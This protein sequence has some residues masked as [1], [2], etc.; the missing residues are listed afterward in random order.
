MKYCNC[1]DWVQPHFFLLLFPALT[2]G[3]LCLSPCVIH[4]FF[5]A[6]AKGNKTSER[7][8]QV[9][10]KRPWLFA[11]HTRSRFRSSARHNNLPILCIRVTQPTAKKP[12]KYKA[13]GAGSLIHTTAAFNKL[14][15][16]AYAR[17][18]IVLQDFA[19]SDLAEDLS[20]PTTG[21]LAPSF[22]LPARPSWLRVTACAMSDEETEY[23]SSEAE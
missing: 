17:P 7:E 14:T 6:C 21:V 11:T 3:E 4:I 12:R 13:N 9:D 1:Y 16:L 18:R 5:Q 19:S 23:C 20:V 15:K 8:K 10:M 2:K 22:P